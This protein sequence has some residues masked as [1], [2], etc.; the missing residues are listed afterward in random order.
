MRCWPRKSYHNWRSRHI[1]TLN[2]LAA[3]AQPSAMPLDEESLTRLR[4]FFDEC[5]QVALTAEFMGW[6]HCS[7]CMRAKPPLT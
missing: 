2:L 6:G 4:L 7:T 5:S 1:A 3:C